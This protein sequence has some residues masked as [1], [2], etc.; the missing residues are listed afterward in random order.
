MKK[1]K[2]K[3]SK[4][5]GKKSARL[6]T[7]WFKNEK[8]IPT[9][10]IVP[11]NI[12][13]MKLKDSAIKNAG[14]FPNSNEHIIEAIKNGV[15]PPDFSSTKPKSQQKPSASVHCI[16]EAREAK[17][18]QPIG[19]P[20]AASKR[21]E[22]QQK[23]LDEM[24]V[25]SR[26]AALSQGR[27]WY[28]GKAEWSARVTLKMK[29]HYSGKAGH[30]SKPDETKKGEFIPASNPDQ[31]CLP[32]PEQSN[33]VMLTQDLIDKEKATKKQGGYSFASR[34]PEVKTGLTPSGKPISDFVQGG[35]Y[36]PKLHSV[37]TE[38]HSAHVAKF[39]SS[40]NDDRC[41]D[42][43]LR[44][45]PGSN[46]AGREWYRNNIPPDYTPDIVHEFDALERDLSK[47]L[48]DKHILAEDN[49]ELQEE[50][51]QLKEQL[52]IM[53]QELYYAHWELSIEKGEDVSD[54]P[55]SEK[56]K[57]LSTASLANLF[58]VFVVRHRDNPLH[59]FCTVHG[60]S[61]EQEQE[62]RA[63]IKLRKQ[64]RNSVY[65]EREWCK[66]MS[67]KKPIVHSKLVQRAQRIREL[68]ALKRETGGYTEYLTDKLGTMKMYKERLLYRKWSRRDVPTWQ[69]LLDNRAYL[70]N[71]IRRYEIRADKRD[72]FDAMKARVEQRELDR[73]LMRTTTY[74]VLKGIKDVMLMEVNPFKIAAN[75]R[76]KKK[77]IELDRQAEIAASKIK[78]LQEKKDAE[79]QMRQRIRE[80]QRL[81]H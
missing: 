36:A 22:T 14:A 11:K 44:K 58:N 29:E 61:I 38:L 70:H 40:A 19:T 31:L 79:Q 78:E 3:G 5:Q 25:Y 18:L 45:Y 76:E 52:S 20:T 35:K 8:D 39:R 72:R 75:R 67:E 71:S 60:V 56:V 41:E 63:Y 24:A 16:N 30:E 66:V 77:A 42:T 50:V 69:S 12:D 2:G 54:R 62:L 65:I 53:K 32:P 59:A 74:K 34:K 43:G 64:Q 28:Q 57:S 27:D 49:F 6:K 1:H 51:E 7:V 73:A 48:V 37:T 10:A 4:H 21:F 15:Y 9:R 80:A 81:A 47:A 13:D 17:G 55:A 23:I 26:W 46:V 68:R 33:Y